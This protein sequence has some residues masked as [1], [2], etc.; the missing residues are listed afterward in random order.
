MPPNAAE[1]LLAIFTR[2]YETGYATGSRLASATTSTAPYWT[3][4]G[5]RTRSTGRAPAWTGPPSRQKGG[6]CGPGGRPESDRPRQGRLQAPHPGRPPGHPAGGLAHGGQRPRLGCLRRPDQGRRADQAATRAPG[7]R[8]DKLHADKGYDYPRCR[9]YLRHRG[10]GC[11]IAR[12]GIESSDKLGRFRWVVEIIL[13]Q[14]TKPRVEAALA[15]RDHIADLHIIVDD[16]YA[17]DQQF[18]QLPTPGEG[19][20]VQILA[21]THT[22]Q[23]LS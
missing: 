8:P 19:C 7:V 10:I 14:L 1:D 4:W 5:Q 18:D 23:S 2:R 12:R 20:A 21:Q 11:R 16:D 15:G 13:S 17:I 9:N 6:R 22:R 3:A